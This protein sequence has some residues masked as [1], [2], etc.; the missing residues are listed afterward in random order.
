[1]VAINCE[2]TYLWLSFFQL[3]PSST[4]DKTRFSSIS[5]IQS[6][7]LYPFLI[8]KSLQHELRDAFSDLNLVTYL[9]VINRYDFDLASIICMNN[10]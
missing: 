4:V 1:M 3:Q 6:I 5:L 8:I 7:N 10:S 2:G 9:S